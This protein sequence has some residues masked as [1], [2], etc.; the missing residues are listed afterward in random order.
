MKKIISKY[1]YAALIFV[2]I[3]TGKNIIAQNNNN[4]FVF[5]GTSSQLY[6]YDGQPANTDANQSGFSFFN[7]TASNNQITVQAWVYLIGDTPPNTEVP[8]IYRT[9]NNGKTFS[10]S[11]IIILPQSA[12]LQGCRLSNGYL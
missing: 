11:V 6:V 10:R 3:I 2:F 8:I 4:S 9:V 7:S 5:N 12:Q 1:F